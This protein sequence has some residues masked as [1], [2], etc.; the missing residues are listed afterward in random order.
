MKKL[1][2]TS[3]GFTNSKIGKCFLEMVNMKPVDIKVLFIPTASRTEHEMFYVRESEK[4][5]IDMGIPK[6][7]I[8]WLDI[9]ATSA[10]GDLAKYNVVYV[11][12]GNTFY[13]AYHMKRIGFD[14]KIVE[15]VNHG[16]VYVGVSAGSVLAGPD[17]SIAGPWDENDVGKDGPWDN[18]DVELRDMRGLNLTDKVATPHYKDEEE[19]I[20]EEFVT[21]LPYKIVRIT[22]NQA[23]KEVDGVNEIIE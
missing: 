23:F 17:I 22:D 1:L 3:T 10:V 21:K 19:K 12:G 2:L 13:L 5:L 4:E 20:I 6:A 7:N 14:K 15:M 18:N 8:V 16:C 11:C 9:N